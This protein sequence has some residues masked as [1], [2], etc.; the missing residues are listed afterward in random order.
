MTA[1]MVHIPR[2]FRYPEAT[3]SKGMAGIVRKTFVSRLTI[4][5]TIPPTYAAVMPS[6][7]ATTVASAPA[8]A[9][10]A[11]DRRAPTTTCEKTSLPWSVVP[12]R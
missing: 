6:T 1:I 2:V 10:S 12:K 3:T 9:P 8:S 5:S 7:A 11:S 4:S